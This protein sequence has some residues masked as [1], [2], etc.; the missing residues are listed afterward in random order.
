MGVLC[1]CFCVCVGVYVCVCI[2]G[3]GISPE[4]VHLGVFMHVWQRISLFLC[5]PV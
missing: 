1:V 5:L 2:R 3:D 4:T